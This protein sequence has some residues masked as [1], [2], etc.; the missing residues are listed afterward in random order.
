MKKKITSNIFLSTALLATI[1][2]LDNIL[3][4]NFLYYY[5][6]IGFFFLTYTIQQ[7]LILKIG[8]TPSS[9]TIIYNVTTMLKMFMSLFFLV[10]YYLLLPEDVDH[11]QKTQFSIFFILIYFIYLIVNTKIFFSGQNENA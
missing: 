4:H 5:I 7:L 2:I 1:L 9:F 3:E 11:N 6:A 8:T 10:A